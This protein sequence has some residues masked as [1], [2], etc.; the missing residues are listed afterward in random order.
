M[1][2][3]DILSIRHPIPKSKQTNKT[4][5]DPQSDYIKNLQQQI[6][7]LELEARY[8]E[9]MKPALKPNSSQKESSKEGNE[10]Y[11]SLSA[12]LEEVNK[13]KLHLEE[14]FQKYRSDAEFKLESVIS[15]IEK[16]KHDN[17]I[18]AA[19]TQMLE[20]RVKRLS[21]TNETLFLNESTFQSKTNSLYT[22]IE[23]LTEIQSQLLYSRDKA[24]A[25]LRE[26]KEISGFLDKTH[27]HTFYRK[28][29][30][31][32]QTKLSE[33]EARVKENN[34]CI[35]NLQDLNKTLK[36]ETMDALKDS[37]DLKI[38][39]DELSSLIKLVI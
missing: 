20:H 38:K 13:Q 24:K 19:E 36:Q 22:R 11:S 37:N 4:M 5:T 21:E 28:K 34:I 27:N 15:E 7:L 12:R 18:M 10:S 2:H 29:Y 30:N 17:E 8:S 31:E 32:A 39:I 35:Q 16:L 14:R 3:Q 25:E 33:L 9:N 1:S 23:E 6:Y 26:Q